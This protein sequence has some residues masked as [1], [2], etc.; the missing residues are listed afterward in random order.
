[1]GRYAEFLPRGLPI[2]DIRKTP[3][4]QYIL[5]CGLGLVWTPCC[6]GCGMPRITLF[7]LDSILRGKIT[8]MHKIKK[9]SKSFFFSLIGNTVEKWFGLVQFLF[10]IHNQVQKKKDYTFYLH[11][12]LLRHQYRFSAA[13]IHFHN[14]SRNANSGPTLGLRSE[15]PSVQSNRAHCTECTQP[16]HLH[17]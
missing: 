8:T 2:T 9:F 17:P 13:K 6:A 15:Y 11:F 1:M 3:D 10:K 7:A 4:T 16:F 12:V 14:S 5:M